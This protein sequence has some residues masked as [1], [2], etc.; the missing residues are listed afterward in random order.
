MKQ[1]KRK[2]RSFA[3]AKSSIYDASLEKKV[4]VILTA[5]PT[6]LNRIQR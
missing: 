5:H 2:G 3:E 4:E 6:N 1:N